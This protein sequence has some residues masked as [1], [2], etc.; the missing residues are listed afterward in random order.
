MKNPQGKCNVLFSAQSFSF[1][2]I[3]RQELTRLCFRV[4]IF[5]DS[6]WLWPQDDSN[7]NA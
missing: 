4:Q 7:F 3:E 6:S 1:F 5:S 2:Y